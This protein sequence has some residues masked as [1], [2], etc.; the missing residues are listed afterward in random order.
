MANASYLSIALSPPT[1]KLTQPIILN[2]SHPVASWPKLP[3]IGI[4][5]NAL[6]MTVKRHDY[7]NVSQLNLIKNIKSEVMTIMNVLIHPNI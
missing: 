2:A 5:H 4:L 7:H 1:N 3:E 6:G